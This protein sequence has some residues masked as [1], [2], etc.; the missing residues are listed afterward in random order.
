MV[1]LLA[2]LDVVFDKDLAFFDLLR[3]PFFL[4]DVV[5]SGISSLLSLSLLLS[6]SDSRSTNHV[7]LTFFFLY[8]FCLAMMLINAV[9]FA[10]F[11]SAFLCSSVAVLQSSRMAKACSLAC[12]RT[13]ASISL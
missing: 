9:R 2:L 11:S 13:S 7:F 10:M 8:N 4:G 5:G 6:L 3:L 1:N 12:L